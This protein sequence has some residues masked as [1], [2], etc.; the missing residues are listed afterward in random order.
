MQKEER[1]N[2]II[3]LKDKLEYG[4]IE[5]LGNKNFLNSNKEVVV[6]GRYSRMMGHILVSPV[7]VSKQ[8][9]D[10]LYG[11]SKF[12]RENPHVTQEDLNEL[13]KTKFFK[14]KFLRKVNKLLPDLLIELRD[15]SAQSVALYYANRVQVN[16]QIE[17]A[18][19]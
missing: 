14:F 1:K 8:Q 16:E 4:Y 6:G 17:K 13:L 5:V 19:P 10:Q 12:L 11:L 9:L 18:L 7:K 2:L 15:Y 3:K